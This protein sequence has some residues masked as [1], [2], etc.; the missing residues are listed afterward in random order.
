MRTLARAEPRFA[1]I[2]K[3]HGPPPLKPR[4]PGLQTLVLLMLERQVSLA[5]GRAMYQRRVVAGSNP[6]CSRSSPRPAT[7]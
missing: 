7:R 2:V 5:Q 4:D 3:R 1:H 6:A